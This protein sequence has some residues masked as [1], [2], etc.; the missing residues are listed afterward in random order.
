MITKYDNLTG[1]PSFQ[2]YS[3]LLKEK[4]LFTFKKQP[5]SYTTQV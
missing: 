1:Y 2:L 5:L 4:R 3:A